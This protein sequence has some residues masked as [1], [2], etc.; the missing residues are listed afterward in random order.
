MNLWDAS[1]SPSRFMCALLSSTIGRHEDAKRHMQ[2]FGITHRVHPNVWEAANTYTCKS[3]QNR[4]AVLTS[5]PTPVQ[6]HATNNNDNDNENGSTDDDYEQQQLLFVPKCRDSILPPEL[7]KRMCR[8]FA[9]DSVYWN[10]S[11]YDTRGYHSY[12]LDLTTQGENKAPQNIIEECIMSHLLPRAKEMMAASSTAT[13]TSTPNA[14]AEETQNNIVGAEWWVH[15]RPVGA[16]LGHQLHFDTDEALL[17]QQKQVTHPLISSVL[18]VT[19]G[20]G[21]D[22]DDKTKKN[23]AAA[24]AAA[25]STIVFHQDPHSNGYAKSAYI[26]RPVDNSFMTFPG[27]LLHGVLPCFSQD[28]SA[29]DN[30]YRDEIKGRH[31]LTFMVGF[32]TR[33][34]PDHIKKRPLYSACGVLPPKTRRH[35]WVSEIVSSLGE[36]RMEA[37]LEQSDES[38]SASGNKINGEAKFDDRELIRVSPAW[39]SLKVMNGEVKND[40]DAVGPMCDLPFSINHRFFVREKHADKMKYFW[41]TLFEK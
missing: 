21:G 9:P 41:D 26:S 14:E 4:T 1:A 2:R 22:S 31:R 34:V 25:G 18:Y 29:A 38:S 13:A 20:D 8:I 3:N 12:W 16:N 28:G 24:E 5:I 40:V 30:N 17:D 11:S 6:I 7:Y 33:R 39:E 10:E 35:T 23:N 27:N 36:M 19:G 15:H 32:W 37:S